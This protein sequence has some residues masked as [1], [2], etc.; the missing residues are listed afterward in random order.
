MLLVPAP[1][2]SRKWYPGIFGSDLTC[3]GLSKAT[4]IN[5]QVAR[6]DLTTQLMHAE[7]E[8]FSKTKFTR[9]L[10]LNCSLSKAQR[11][12]LLTLPNTQSFVRQDMLNIR[13]PAS[14]WRLSI[15]SLNSLSPTSCKPPRVTKPR[16]L[17]LQANVGQ[18]SRSHSQ[19]AES[20]LQQGSGARG[21]PHLHRK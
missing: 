10:G 20:Y 9:N 17:L 18:R 16:V 2:D 21:T 7:P 8:A 11:T 1:Y 19:G 5:W 12:I 6:D 13:E 4:R 3:S 14:K 15:T